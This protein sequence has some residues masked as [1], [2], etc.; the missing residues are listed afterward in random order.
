[1]TDII[2]PYGHSLIQH[3]KNSNRIY[4]MKCDAAEADS[5]I[6]H[7]NQLA[8]DKNYSKIVAKIPESQDP[9]FKADGY[10][11][12]AAIPG[13]YRGQ[14][15]CKLL[16]KYLCPKRENLTN[17]MEIK[18]I[19]DDA[20]KKRAEA[21]TQAL[22]EE[23]KIR[24]LGPSDIPALAQIYGTVFKSYPF[25]IFDADY[26]LET[27]S[28][29]VTYFGVFHNNHL[30]AVSSSETDLDNL[31]Y[32]MTDFAVLPA[33]RGHKLALHL[34]NE[35]EKYMINAGFRLLYTIARAS[36]YGMNRTFARAN[37]QYGGTLNNNTQISGSIESMNIW[38]K[39]IGAAK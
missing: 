8:H 37:Y 22:P 31:N 9:V 19:L 38:Y 25:P 24:E 11:E 21:A 16:S 26:L 27:M 29:H 39:D 30:V 36:S 3:G 34:L 5:L 35:M 12:E 1:M 13:S 33:Y 14:E 2:E 23:F 10:K 15:T 20:I 17:D 4:L 7:M 32:E 18:Q 28:D 6:T